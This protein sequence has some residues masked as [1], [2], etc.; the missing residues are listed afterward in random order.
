MAKDILALLDEV[1]EADLEKVRGEIAAVTA[2]LEKLQAT[3]KLLDVQ[4]HGSPKKVHWTKRKKKDDAEAKPSGPAEDSPE[5]RRLKID[6][7]LAAQSLKVAEIAQKIG[8]T[9]API[10][11]IIAHE[12]F[13]K[14]PDGLCRLTLAGK[15]AIGA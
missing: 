3:E 7:L 10:Y 13:A 14:D 4:L 2:R 6:R 11:T 12:W 15:K 1:T 5:G 9:P 8:M